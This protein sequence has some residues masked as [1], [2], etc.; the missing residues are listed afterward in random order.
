MGGHSELRTSDCVHPRFGRH[1]CLEKCWA[2]EAEERPTAEDMI[3]QLEGLVRT[4][5]SIFKN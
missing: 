2:V 3:V 1:D 4:G 5:T